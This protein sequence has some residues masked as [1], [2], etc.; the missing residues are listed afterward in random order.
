M[1]DRHDGSSIDLERELVRYMAERRIT[2][3][4]PPGPGRE[5][6]GRGGARA[7]HRR[8]HERDAPRP[9]RRARPRP[10]RAAASAPPSA[11]ATPRAD[12]RP[13][14]RGRAVRLQLG[15]LHG[16]GRRPVVRGQ[17][18]DQG[19]VRLLRQ[20]RHDVRQDRPGRRRLRRHVPDVG[21]HPGA[22]RAE[23]RPAARPVAHPQHREPRQGMGEPRLRPGQRPLRPVH[24]V[25]DGRRL[26]QRE[27]RGHARQLGRAVGP[28]VR[29]AHRGPRRLARGVRRGA[30]PPRP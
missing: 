16:R 14:A 28:D 21:G 5:A 27:G 10:R 18:R 30:V 19:H 13:L 17:V 23:P 7:G 25:D 29:P 8:L 12:A 15:G 26:R 3:R 9:R 20:L 11:A 1:T 6:R 22:A 4:A 24:V 2:R